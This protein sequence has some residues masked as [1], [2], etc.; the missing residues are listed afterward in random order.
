MN[1]VIILCLKEQQY[2]CSA[3]NLALSIK[4]HNPKIHITLLTDG[5]HQKVFRT[6]HY[7]VFDNIKDVEASDYTDTY[8]FSPAK[9][10]LSIP[11][12]SMYDK[13]LYI[14]ADTLCLNNLQP[15][16]DMLDGSK[17]KSNVVDNYISWTTDEEFKKVFKVDKT[18]TIN[19]SWI[20]FENDK[21]FK[22][23]NK[24]FDKGFD[25]EKIAPNWGSKLPDELFFNAS[26]SKLNIDASF[27]EIMYFDEKGKQMQI[28][29]LNKYYFIT[30]YGN[31]NS[32]NLKF[33][34]YYD[35]V[36]FKI[37]EHYGIE[38][39]FKIHDILSKKHIN[40][41]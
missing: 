17:F 31:R 39:R 12:Y 35:R 38:N 23:A 19:T 22:Q 8:G 13:T 2:A 6:E 20:Y 4:F 18:V 9:A 34:E 25:L 16:F 24:Y 1:G 7:A 41:K 10:K 26:I 32:T 30:Y 14:D 33:I 5:V 36:M 3:V 40:N 27:K 29:D 11:K 21:V 37:C 15:L 28:S